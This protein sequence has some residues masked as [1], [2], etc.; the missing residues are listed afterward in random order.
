M[1]SLVLSEKKWEELILKN[2]HFTSGV[3]IKSVRKRDECTDVAFDTGLCK[4]RNVSLQ[5]AACGMYT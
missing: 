3:I 1:G 2:L 4:H 5:D